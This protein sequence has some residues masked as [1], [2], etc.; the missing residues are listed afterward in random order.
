[1][2]DPTPESG[3]SSPPPQEAQ[4]SEE[5]VLAVFGDR[6]DAARP[7]TANDVMDEL[8][9]SRRTAHNKLNALVEREVLETRKVGA[10]SRVWWLPIPN[11]GGPAAERA[12]VA[13]PT[14]DT[15]VA[16]AELPGSG[17]LLKQRREALQAAYDYVSEHPN[18]TKSEFLTE[19]F[20][21]YPAGCKTADE[22]WKIIEPA[23]TDLPTVDVETDRGHVWRFV[24]G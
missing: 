15:E 10:R 7:L 22:W 14:V 17:E 3:G 13:E 12:P 21:D 8:G 11:S 1:M 5:D 16:N 20:P 18:A 19:V 23:L 4:F 2:T 24:K 9:C 6:S